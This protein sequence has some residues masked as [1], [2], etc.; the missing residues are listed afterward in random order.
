VPVKSGKL[1]KIRAAL[2]SPMTKALAEV[3]GKLSEKEKN[4]IK[5]SLPGQ[6]DARAQKG[7]P[8]RAVRDLRAFPIDRYRL[9]DD[10]RK[11]KHVATERRMLAMQLATHADPDG[12]SITIGV[13]RLVKDIGIAKR[14]L[15]RRL[16]ELKALG[17]LESDGLTKEHGTRLRNLNFEKLKAGMPDSSEMPDRGAGMPSKVAY[18]ALPAGAFLLAFI[19]LFARWLYSDIK[20]PK[21]VG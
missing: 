4:E 16:D 17:L 9:P 20:P 11:W 13:D 8:V 7:D 6:P 3:I 19:G 15:A 21:S 1:K 10:A 18:S 2:Q 5:E 14:T 12:T